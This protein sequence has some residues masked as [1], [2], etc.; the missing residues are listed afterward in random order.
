MARTTKTSLIKQ[1]L[2]EHGYITAKTAW[3]QFGAERLGSI[4]F[5]LRER[6]MDIETQ[7]QISKDRYGNTIQFAKYIYRGEVDG[8]SKA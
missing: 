1:V 8:T 6:G 2:I 7:M 4:I 3:E 5:N